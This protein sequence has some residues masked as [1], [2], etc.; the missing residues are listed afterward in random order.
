MLEDPIHHFSLVRFIQDFYELDKLLLL[1]FPNHRVPLPKL[2]HV[3][4]KKNLFASLKKKMKTSARRIENYL[5]HSLSTPIGKTS[6]FRDFLSAQRDEDRVISKTI[7]RQ[8]VTQHHPVTHNTSPSLPPSPPPSSNPC[9]DSILKDFKDESLMLEPELSEEEDLM[10]SSILGKQQNYDRMDDFELIKVLGKGATGKVILVR[11][12]QSHKLFA[13]KSITKSWSITRREVE[14][15]RMERDILVALSAIRHP[16]LI[17]LH[18]AF[19]DRQNLYLVLDYHAGADLATLL[20]RYI[21]F[22]PEQCRLY[23]AEIVMGL[24]ELHR[25]NILYRDLKPENV[26]LAA[27]GHLVLTDFGLSKLFKGSD[28][29]DHRTTT[30]CGTP[31]Y[32]APEIILQ[33]EEY[34]YAAD[35]WSLGTMLYEMLTG[36]TPF[37]AETPEDMYDRVLYD[38]LTFPA[39]F[40]PEAMDLIAGLL[41]RDPLE[42]LGAGIGGVF[43]L[44][45]HAYFARHLNWKDVHAKRIQP[46]YVPSRTSE[47]DLSN[48]D[49]DFLEMST[50]IKEENDEAILL[51]Q[52]WL[53]ESCPLGLTEHAFRGYSYI[54]P[55]E[56]R[57][58]PYGSEISFFSSDYCYE[59][60]EDEEDSQYSSP[61]NTASVATSTSSLEQKKLRNKQS[62]PMMNTACFNQSIRNSL[63][64][65]KEEDPS[66]WRS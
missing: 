21:C 4:K 62:M 46:L 48:F 33:D 35:F 56:L 64:I 31:E 22:H 15:I 8:M 53:P 19:Q 36:V 28:R 54:E 2:E 47:T 30:F 55:D 50:H 51:R 41:E 52:R 65:N 20:Q 58:I 43:E 32:L 61:L 39:R 3:G 63:I 42:R 38:D 44:R 40:D 13:L 14:H 1:H 23:A 45:T 7:V 24:Q 66:A 26:L 29:Y 27:D 49:P 11:E 60:Y 6:L 18:A 9:C 10:C 5:R 25:N 59:D 57:D 37:A 16:F 17:R 34:S 12:Q